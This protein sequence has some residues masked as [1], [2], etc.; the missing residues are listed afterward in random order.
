MTRGEL[1]ATT[2]AKVEEAM[3][4]LG[5]ASLLAREAGRDDLAEEL[6][7]ARDA[8]GRAVFANIRVEDLDA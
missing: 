7:R 6:L 5:E 3:R 4:K 1:L 2:K 8:S